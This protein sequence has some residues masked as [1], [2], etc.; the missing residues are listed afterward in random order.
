[1][2]R[3]D[4]IPTDVSGLFWYHGNG[5]NEP[6]PVKLDKDNHPGAMKGF[7]GRIQ[8]WMREGEYLIGPQLPPASTEL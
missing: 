5:K 7:N 3:F 1:M 6:E 4:K 2:N 8:A